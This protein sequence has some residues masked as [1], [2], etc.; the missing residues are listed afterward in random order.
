M[1]FK[2]KKITKLLGIKNK[3]NVEINYVVFG[4]QNDIDHDKFFNTLKEKFE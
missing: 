3:P 1:S 4:P 2:D